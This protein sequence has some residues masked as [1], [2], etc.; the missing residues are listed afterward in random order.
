CNV[1][2]TLADESYTASVKFPDGYYNKR[3]QSIGLIETP[4]E[5]P[6]KKNSATSVLNLILSV[7]SVVGVAMTIYALLAEQRR[8]LA[9]NLRQEWH[10][11][12]QEGGTANS[13]ARGSLLSESAGESGPAV[14]RSHSL[15]RFRGR[16]Y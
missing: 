1:S 2:N 10:W 12:G 5:E 8:T 4:I 11:P 9:Y 7:C 15:T 16:D 13:S 3:P 14:S 6:N